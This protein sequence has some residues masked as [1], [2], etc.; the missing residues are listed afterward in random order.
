LSRKEYINPY[1]ALHGFFE[2]KT[3]PEWRDVLKD[4]LRA[5]IT[6]YPINEGYED[7]NL[8]VTCRHLPELL[9]AL[10]LIYVRKLNAE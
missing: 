1:K 5:A 6:K 3:L 7:R 8:F 9:K 2:W 10:H 4:L